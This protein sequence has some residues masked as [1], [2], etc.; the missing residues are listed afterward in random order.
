ME[1][2]NHKKKRTFQ[3]MCLCF[4][5]LFACCLACLTAWFI[6]QR[7]AEAEMQ[8]ARDAYVSEGI[9]SG[10]ETDPDH[11][12][13]SPGADNGDGAEGAQTAGA[14]GDPGANNGNDMEGTEAADSDADDGT[15]AS[16]GV[17]Q[18]ADLSP[19]GI[20]DRSIDWAALQE[21]NEDVYAWVTVPGTAIDYPVLQHP[22]EMDYYLEHLLDGS[23]GNAGC[24]YTQ[25]MNSKDWSDRNTILYGHNLRAG[26]MFA[27]LH[28]F[29]DADFFEENRYIHI[30]SADGRI[31]VYEI[32]A[33]YA[34][35]DAHILLTYD[36]MTEEGYGQYLDVTRESAEKAGHFR[37][38]AAPDAT[39]NM[40]TL[41]TCVRGIDNQRYL[42][43]GTL[44]AEGE[45]P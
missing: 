1:G 2:G 26:T 10:E 23:K 14:E 30:Y 28:D 43:Q 37:E 12:G 39:D 15:E 3:I 11:M 9:N 34:F 27:G 31:L 8:A 41:S 35:S 25:R 42:V 29:E 44:I 32:F 13:G 7:K 19:Y 24:I 21:E 5:I 45:Q 4:G 20:T 38:E 16:E 40:I 22:E 6:G 36:F 18:P 33:A 17:N